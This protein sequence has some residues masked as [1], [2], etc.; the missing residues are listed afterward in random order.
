MHRKGTQDARGTGGGDGLKAE[1]VEILDAEL[2]GIGVPYRFA[3][4]FTVHDQV[5]LRA[6][7]RPDP[8]GDLSEDR[9]SHAGKQHGAGGGMWYGHER[10]LKRTPDLSPGTLEPITQNSDRG[11]FDDPPIAKI[12]SR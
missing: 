2:L 10:T 7:D 9:R 8:D 12:R 11:K 3:G 4:T 5:C 6:V 1:V